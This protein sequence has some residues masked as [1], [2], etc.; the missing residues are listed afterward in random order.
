MSMLPIISAGVY[1]YPKDQALR[2][3][4]DTINEFLLDNDMLVY[5]VIFDKDS[6]QIAVNILMM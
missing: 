5:I 2:I 3:A 4:V 1:C 6:L